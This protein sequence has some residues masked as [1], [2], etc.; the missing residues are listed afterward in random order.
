MYR[1]HQHAD[2]PRL[3]GTILLVLNDGKGVR[4]KVTLAFVCDAAA[5]VRSD[6]VNAIGIL[7]ELYSAEYPFVRPQLFVVVGIEAS[8]AEVGQ[9][10]HLRVALHGP[11]GT[12]IAAVD[13]SY[14]VGQPPLHRKTQI[15]VWSPQLLGHRVSGSR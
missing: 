6:K 10:K 12:E 5:Q 2:V 11:D 1:L 7:N 8:V 9:K 15:R 14:T 3:R 4:K 13:S